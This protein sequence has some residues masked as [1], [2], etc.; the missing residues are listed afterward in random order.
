MVSGIAVSAPA[1]GVLLLT[2]DR[3]PVNAFDAQLY[4]DATA[5]FAAAAVDPEVRAVV[6]TGAG[7]RAFSAGTDLTAPLDEVKPPNLRFFDTLSR[8]PLP[9]VGAVN[10]PAVGGGAMIAAECDVLV[11]CEEAFFQIPELAHSMVGGGAHIKRLAPLFK[12][13][14]ML[15]LGERLTAAEAERYGLLA[16]LVPRAEVVPKAV[17]L[18]AE[19][20]ALDAAAVSAARSVFRE[21]DAARIRR[22][23]TRELGFG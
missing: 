5:A 21:E 22:E 11:A 14:R 9:V 18:A 16:A 15:L 7:D 6:L 13:Q 1:P 8:F 2:V 4:D 12:A 19:I 23:Y 17:A 3:P 20:A 10:A